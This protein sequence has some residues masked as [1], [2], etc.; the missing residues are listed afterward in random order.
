MSLVKCWDVQHALPKSAILTLIKSS[1]TISSSLG[2]IKSNNVLSVSECLF[3]IVWISL[4]DIFDG[5][6]FEEANEEFPWDILWPASFFSSTV[7][8]TGIGRDLPSHLFIWFECVLAIADPVCN[9]LLLVLDNGELKKELD[10][11]L[12]GDGSGC[13]LVTIDI[14]LFFP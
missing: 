12:R 14:A 3:I 1:S 4:Y 13:E 8:F 6:S 7:L 9:M 5:R 11:D 2:G 10:L